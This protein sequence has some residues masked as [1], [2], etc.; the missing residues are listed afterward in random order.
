VPHALKKARGRL[1]I[2]RAGFVA[3]ARE[4]GVEARVEDFAFE[5]WNPQ[6]DQTTL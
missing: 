4:N 5:T 1:N 6:I 2:T 3:E